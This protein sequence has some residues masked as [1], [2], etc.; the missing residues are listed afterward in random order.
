M[1][2][3]NYITVAGSILFYALSFA[4]GKTIKTT[5]VIK[6][7]LIQFSGIIV[8]RDSLKP[9]S[10]TKIIITNSQRGTTSDYYGY[11][12]FVAHI[13]DT[14]EF[15][16]VGFKKAIFIIPDTLS[17]NRYSLIQVLSV[18]TIMLKETIIY[19]WPTKEQFEQNFLTASI[20]D[21]DTEKAKKNLEREEMKI[22]YENMPMDGSMNF[23]ASMQQQYSKL[24]YAGQYPPNNLLNP[25]AWAKFIKAW[26]NGDFKKQ[27]DK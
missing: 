17:T 21:D 24:Y 15:S 4:Q 2:K 13:S 16:A 25:I 1:I 18:D 8:E 12:S 5:S 23:K 9:V 11:F 19:P 3:K 27:D 14:I 26:K 20:P 10:F 7:S 6:D 22:Q